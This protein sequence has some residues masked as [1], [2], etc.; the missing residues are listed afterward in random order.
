MSY[1]PLTPSLVPRAAQ[2]DCSQLT[3]WRLR[4][5]AAL[6]IA[7]GCV[8]GIDAWFKWQPG[9]GDSFTSYLTKALD[10][11]PPAVATWITFWL[12]V[13]SINPHF[14]AFIV[15][16]GETGIALGLL[17]GALSNLT[18]LAGILLSLSIWSTAQGFGGP[19]GP[20]STDIGVSIIYVLVF[21]GLFLSNAGA[22]FGLDRFLPGILGRWRFLA[23][24]SAS[25]KRRT[26]ITGPV[27]TPIPVAYPQVALRLP[28]QPR[29]PQ[30]TSLSAY[31]QTGRQL[32]PV[33]YEPVEE[34]QRD[35]ERVEVA[36]HGPGA[37]T[38]SSRFVGMRGQR[39]SRM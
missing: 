21:T 24:S 20:G 15:A 2:E 29:Q 39:L 34:D 4:G 36:A 13:I 14:F 19:Y 1:R 6:R 28:S 38:A 27:R 17:F 25:T 11:Q 30:P 22:V 32:Y 35:W 8:W 31:R 26:R 5:I 37:A 7:F 16:V 9:F 33:N 18:C 10:G 12:H 23:A 3:A